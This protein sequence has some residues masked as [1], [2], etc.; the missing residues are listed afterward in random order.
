MNALS[1]QKRIYDVTYASE[2]NKLK[3]TSQIRYTT[4]SAINAQ[5]SA[6]MAYLIYYIGLLNNLCKYMQ[7]TIKNIDNII[8]GIK[9]RIELEKLIAGV[10]F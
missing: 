3:T 2:Y 9:N 4:E 8:F 5:I 10:K 7:D 1:T 6:N